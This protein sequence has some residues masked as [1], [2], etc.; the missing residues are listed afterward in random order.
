MTDIHNRTYIMK[1]ATGEMCDQEIIINLDANLIIIGEENSYKADISDEG[2]TTYSIPSNQDPFTFSV[3]S[4]EGQ[5]AIDLHTKNHSEIIPINLQQIVL[6]ELFPIS[7]KHIDTP[8]E[9]PIITEDI[10][11]RA[12]KAEKPNS[13]FKKSPYDYKVILGISLFIFVF[14]SFIYLQYNSEATNDIRNKS[15]ENIISGNH[16]PVIITEGNKNDILIL[17][18]SQRDFDW[19]MQ[20]LLKSKYRNNFSIKKTDEIE[21]EIERKLSETMPNLLKVEITNP[22]NPVVKLLSEKISEKEDKFIN[23]IFSNYFQCYK[24]NEVKFSNIDD[25]IKK[26]ELGLTESNVKWHRIS[27]N[28]KTIFVVKDSLND[29]Q[30][31]SLI[32][33]VSGF[34]K[35]WGERQIQFSISLANNEFAGK[36]FITNSDGYILLG[37]NH[38][39]FNS[40]IL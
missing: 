22:C 14:I 19:S 3:I 21:R 34:Y 11:G 23:L 2:F 25:L 35:Q 6:K 29:K 33:F 18:K 9:E 5:I 7:I 32:T 15:I 8:W 39:L 40:K 17:V 16:H 20:H 26:A 1:L 10:I 24:Q 36:S 27:K 12:I 37:H 38:W 31:I 13:R 28:N 30:T 4:Y